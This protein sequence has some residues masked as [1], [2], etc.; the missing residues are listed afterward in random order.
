MIAEQ[1]NAIYAATNNLTVD[2]LAD[3][4]NHLGY[5]T[6]TDIQ[7]EPWA[8]HVANILPADDDA[9]AIHALWVLLIEVHDSRF[10]QRVSL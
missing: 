4:V 10:S 8:H 5:G 1:L 3:L 2:E 6:L 9:E 7:Q